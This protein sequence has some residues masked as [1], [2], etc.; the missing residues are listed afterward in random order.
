M[1]RLG[2]RDHHKMAASGP[3]AYHKMTAMR[4]SGQAQ[5]IRKLKA[6]YHSKMEAVVP[7]RGQSGIHPRGSF[8]APQP[9]PVTYK[10]RKVLVLTYKVADFL[11]FPLPVADPHYCVPQ[12]PF[13]LW[14]S[15]VGCHIMVRTRKSPPKQCW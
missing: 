3:E 4:N 12:G 6:M 15:G 9:A 14:L 8:E 5:D 7:K 11:Q 2:T 13:F 1:L 10:K